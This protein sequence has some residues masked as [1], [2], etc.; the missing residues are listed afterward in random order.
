MGR[1]EGQVHLPAE[2]LDLIFQLLPTRDL[3][4]VV[5]VCSFW[6]EVGEAPGLWSRGVICLA[7]GNM[8]MLPEVLGA[9]RML[10]VRSLR[11][12]DWEDMPEETVEVVVGHQGLKLLDLRGVGLSSVTSSQLARLVTGLQ[13]VWLGYCPLAS[14]QAEAILAGV[15]RGS[16]LSRLKL[17]F[18]D[19]STVEPGLLARAVS[20]LEEVD[21]SSSQLT[22]QQTQAV[23]RAAGNSRQLKKLDLAM[24]DSLPDVK[25]ELLA[26]AVLNLEEFSI[27]YSP[28][29]C[30]QIEA[31]FSSINGATSLKALR[32]GYN[33]IIK[34][35]DLRIEMTNNMEG[36]IN[37]LHTVKRK[38]FLADVDMI[39][40]NAAFY[41]GYYQISMDQEWYKIVK[42][43]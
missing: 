25:P 37:L 38:S 22:V 23:L 27:G 12:L 30:P 9:R 28:V 34:F 13:E 24:N 40:L 7:R 32:I 10:L 26:S 2:M 15:V 3:M 20:G 5:Q 18:T 14:S 35:P 43:D 31:I 33:R 39:L 17:S 4:V 1:D 42:I 36:M 11:V 6:R 8:S 16:K 19:L 21:L 29:S 41:L